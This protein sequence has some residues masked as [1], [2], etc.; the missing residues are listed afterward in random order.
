VLAALRPAAVDGVAADGQ[1]LDERELFERQLGARV[2]LAG[3]DGEPGPQA[4]V[5]VDAKHLQ[6]L[7]A[8]PTAAWQAE[9]F[10]S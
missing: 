5:G 2:E 1:R 8:V 9:Q 7:A 3:G 6:V 4:A 10:G